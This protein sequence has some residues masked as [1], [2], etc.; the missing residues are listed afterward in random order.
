MKGRQAIENNQKRN[1]TLK[2]GSGS[3]LLILYREDYQQ[4]IMVTL[5]IKRLFHM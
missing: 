5:N 4:I 2:V 1:A 3:Q